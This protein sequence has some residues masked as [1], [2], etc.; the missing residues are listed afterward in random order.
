[1]SNDLVTTTNNNGP[2]LTPAQQNQLAELLQSSISPKTLTDYRNS[3]K[4][5]ANY[6]EAMNVSSLPATVQTVTAYILG[7]ANN[8][9]GPIGIQPV[10]AAIGYAHESANLPNPCRSIEVKSVMKG[11]RRKIGTMTKPKTAITLDPLK[12]MLATLADDLRG[13]RDRAMLIVGYA[14]GFRRGELVALNVDDV[15]IAK[16]G[17]TIT[18]KRSKTDQVGKGNFKQLP[19]M[20][21]KNICPVSA[22]EQWIKAAN[23]ATGP[24][25]RG[26][27][28][29][30]HLS[31]DGL[32]DKEIARLVK[33]CADKAGLDPATVSGHSLRS[34]FVTEATSAGIGDTEI[35]EQTAHKN[36]DMLARYKQLQGKGATK[37]ARAALGG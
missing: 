20:S 17:A 26:I 12:A 28:R 2:T 24:L 29:W 21:D 22:L 8:G 3:F 32:T 36:S 6:C 27:D 7:M 13:K 9:R 35:M 25:F 19:R 16:T 23:I 34:G 15:K 10:L 18:I 11:L 14:G 4:H 1:M 33:R 37:A 30:G 5:F 31:N